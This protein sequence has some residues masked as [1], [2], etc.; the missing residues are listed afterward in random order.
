MNN[1]LLQLKIQQRLNKLASND[2]DNIECWQIV[3]AF[4]KGQLEWCRR[5][6]HG[7]NQYHEGD[8]SSTIRI[9][10]LQVLLK[11]IPL[12]GSV[13]DTY[14]ETTP[15][16]SDFFKFKKVST[17]AIT[18]CCPERTLLVYEAEEHNSDDLL[19]DTNTTPSF[20]WAETF[21]TRMGNKIRIYTGNK[22]QVTKPKLTY[23]RLPVYIKIAGC[24][25]EQGITTADV[26]CEFKDDI[27]ELLID[28]C[29]SILAGDVGD[30]Y[31]E[32]RSGQRTEKNN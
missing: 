13:K 14:Y 3:E 11:Q 31:T 10:D 23:Y 16:P 4:N 9:D 22:F 12:K 8:E 24:I 1:N 19:N 15:L 7:G 28:E 27:T 29:V 21:C 32:Q 5:Q 30:Q 25:D 26:P 6:L 2:Y 20:E 17:K 18:D